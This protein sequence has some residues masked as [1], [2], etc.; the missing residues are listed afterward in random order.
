MKVSV[1]VPCY[2]EE[3]SVERFYREATAVFSGQAFDYELIFVDDGSS[4]NTFLKLDE[5][6]KADAKVKV[7]SFSRNFGQQ[8]AIICGFRASTGDAV[9]EM[10]CDLQD[11]VEVVLEMVKRFEEGFEVVHGRRLSRKGESRFKKS[12]AKAY[13]KFLNKITTSKIP[14]NTG[15]FKLLSR[16]VCDIICELS[17]KGKYLRGLES[18]V[19][20]KQTFVDFE[21]H[22]R[23][24]GETKY[25]LK[26]M[27]RLAKDGVISFS[28]WPLTLSIKFG[29]G[30]S[31]L[32]VVAAI[33]LAV[34]NIC[35]VYTHPLYYLFPFNGLIG[36]LLMVFKGISDMYL[37]KTYE[38]VKDRPEYVIDKKINL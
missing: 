26:K 10:D 3:L 16:R 29:I 12:T 6:A 15:D 9:V 5:L 37:H 22:A 36:G 35:G 17:E 23:Q 24:E 34:L 1:V 28:E 32:S 27:V 18:W 2:N 33:V 8:A 38:Q 25:T 31:A 13:Y 19:G 11:P 14:Q 30:F 7:L 4:D 21:R 20:F